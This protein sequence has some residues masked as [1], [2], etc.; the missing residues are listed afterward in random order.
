M[1]NWYCSVEINIILDVSNVRGYGERL[2]GFGGVS[3]PV[4]LKDFFVNV[5]KILNGAY[6][7]KLTSLE[8]MLILEES[9]KNTVSGNIRRV[10]GMKQGNPQDDDFIT[11]KDNLWVC[12]SEGKWKIDP[13]RD[14]LRMSNHTAV[15]HT[16]PSLETIKQSV[17]KQLYSGEG[18]IQYAP[19]AIARANVDLLDTYEKKCKFISKYLQSKDLGRAYLSTLWMVKNDC[20][21]IYRCEIQDELDHRMGRYRLNTSVTGD[22][23][24]HTE[25]GAR[26]VKDLIGKQINVYVNGRTYSTTD[27]GFFF[28]GIKQVYQLT[29][30]EGYA[31][32]LTPNHQLARVK[33]GKQEWIEAGNLSIGDKIV[34]HNHQA[35]KSWGGEGTENDGYTRGKNFSPPNETASY[36]Y[37]RGYF[38]GFLE[39]QITATPVIVDDECIMFLQAYIDKLSSVQQLQRMLLRVGVLSS[40]ESFS[41]GYML[42]IVENSLVRLL[43][44]CNYTIAELLTRKG[45][46]LDEEKLSIINSL[47]FKPQPFIAELPPVFSVSDMQ[48]RWREAKQGGLV[49]YYKKFGTVHARRASVGERITTQIN[50]QAETTKTAQSGDWIVTGAKGEQYVS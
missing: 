22:T 32:K 38:K 24:V 47:E 30:K 2:K 34:I 19:E 44:V 18:A 16:I 42:K 29:T 5:A 36:E 35:I 8:V 46:Q 11:A 10:A 6:G 31:I 48:S 4:Y 39:R 20:Y 14:A 45:S 15:Y 37:Y 28:T 50:G 43:E 12:D 41:S 26:Q 40:F 7:R 23:Q 3:N 17:T 33:D 9:A 21:D 1:E 13:R 25:N 27:K 49:N